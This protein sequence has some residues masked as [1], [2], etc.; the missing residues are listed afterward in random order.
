MV[1]EGQEYAAIFR[2]EKPHETE[3]F[4]GLLAQV[5]VAENDVLLRP[6]LS[7]LN[8][9]I[10]NANAH[11]SYRDLLMITW[12]LELIRTLILANKE[13]VV[14]ALRT[15]LTNREYLYLPL[16]AH[17]FDVMGT[18]QELLPVLGEAAASRESPLLS[19]EIAFKTLCTAKSSAALPELF[20]LCEGDPLPQ[21]I[22]NQSLDVFLKRLA[23]VG[24]KRAA[25]I[26]MTAV[27]RW[28]RSIRRDLADDLWPF[29]PYETS[30]DNILKQVDKLAAKASPLDIEELTQE[31]LKIITELLTTSL[32]EGKRSG[33]IFGIPS[34]YRKVYVKVIPSF[35]RTLTKLLRQIP[36]SPLHVFADL[37][38]KG[39]ALPDWH[40]D[41]THFV[42]PLL[43]VSEGTE[44]A[45]GTSVVQRTRDYLLSTPDPELLELPERVIVHLL[46]GHLQ[47]V[48][49]LGDDA[50]KAI[51][52]AIKVP[53][54][55]SVALELRERALEICKELPSA[56]CGLEALLLD[57][58]SPL[59]TRRAVAQILDE[60]ERA[61]PLIDISLHAQ[62]YKS[63]VLTLPLNRFTSLPP[64]QADN[65]DEVSVLIKALSD[66]N[67]SIRR[68]AAHSCFA[69]VERNRQWFQEAHCRALLPFLDDQDNSLRN[70]VA[71]VFSRLAPFQHEGII[72]GLRE[73]Y[74]HAR[75]RAEKD[76]RRRQHSS[77]YPYSRTDEHFELA[78]AL[79]ITQL[80]ERQ[81]ELLQRLEGEGVV[82]ALGTTLLEERQRELLQRLEGEAVR[83]GRDIHDEILGRRCGDLST[84]IDEAD[85]HEAKNQLDG[86]VTDLRRIMNNLSPQDLKTDGL[87][88]TISNRLDSLKAR[89]L[90]RTSEFEARFECAPEV[91]DE[92]IKQLLTQESHIDQLYRIVLE[93]MT[94][95]DKHAKGHII[96]VQIRKLEDGAVEINVCDDGCGNGGPFSSG[97]GIPTMKAR[98]EAIGVNI[99]F[100]RAFEC[101]GTKIVIR[102]D[103]EG[104]N[105]IP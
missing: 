57:Q 73:A 36:N 67:P 76:P 86:L 92:I 70:V 29:L 96:S 105:P 72:Q 7:E 66:K 15:I 11:H 37:L 8:K 93:A 56:Q 71:G 99:K 21:E 24:D 47:E 23:G 19:R 78:A 88:K 60:L 14:A 68:Q 35:H 77:I 49:T 22:V 34:Q 50:I 20:K 97:N 41:A 100:E 6:F 3:A 1:M 5:A 64:P 51:V 80:E 79:G 40:P 104:G 2:S 102:L 42:I 69:T 28:M 18:M 48:I 89:V 4:K 53:S 84:A 33:P 59:A 44:K 63:L 26:G 13:V 91:T 61:D 75:A 55:S 17:A 30:T 62:V 103:A 46:R 87:L 65:E 58:D 52:E 16:M 39:S 83:I 94:N 95:S 12:A 98:A 90:Q 25:S 101:G 31:L 43:A 9:A 10:A 27:L 82:A 45:M 81:Q 38:S 74:K 32:F 85:Y 54:Q